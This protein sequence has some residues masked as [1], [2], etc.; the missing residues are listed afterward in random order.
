[1]TNFKLSGGDE[2]MSTSL[3]TLAFDPDEL[4]SFQPQI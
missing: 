4:F 2:G 3:Q 1:M